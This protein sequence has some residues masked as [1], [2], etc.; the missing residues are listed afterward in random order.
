MP[1]FVRGGLRPAPSAGA[2]YP[3]DLYLVAGTVEG[4][5][6]G[7]YYYSSQEHSLHLLARGDMRE[8]L[9]EACLGQ[10]FVGG[11]PASIVWSAVFAR[12]T[13]KYGERG[14]D[15]YVCMDLGHSGQ[16]VYLQCGSLG[17]GTCAVGAF[18]DDAVHAA[19]GMTDEEEALYVMPVGRPAGKR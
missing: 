3:L 7:I 6:P 13:V 15:R 5:E 8:A 4:L 17:L 19:V 16:N 1:A 2:L 12:N 14:R 18:D 9:M 10:E 11:A